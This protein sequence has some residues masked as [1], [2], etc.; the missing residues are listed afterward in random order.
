MNSAGS[1]AS[2]A[3]SVVIENTVI[4]YSQSFNLLGLDLLIVFDKIIRIRI[5]NRICNSELRTWI[6]EADQLQIYHNK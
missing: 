4:C 5:R 6:R 3:I 1:G 2:L